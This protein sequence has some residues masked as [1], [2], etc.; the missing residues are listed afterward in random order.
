MSE[1]E[2]SC[3]NN[4]KLGSVNSNL[5]KLACQDQMSRVARETVADMIAC[6]KVIPIII[7]ELE[8]SS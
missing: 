2:N 7:S 1:S 6:E 5:E 4:C 8:S 3:E